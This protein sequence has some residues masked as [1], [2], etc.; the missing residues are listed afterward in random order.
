M[1][2]VDDVDEV[3]DDVDDVVDDVDDHC[4]ERKVEQMATWTDA[5]QGMDV[6]SLSAWSA[7]L[8]Y[9]KY[10]TDFI[11]ILDMYRRCR[12]FWAKAQK[13]NKNV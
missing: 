10:Y 5:Q 9:S 3:V 6:V 8:I 2:G 13:P 1:L 11:W 7:L 4:E 12:A